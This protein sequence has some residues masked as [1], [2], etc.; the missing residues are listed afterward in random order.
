LKT[1]AEQFLLL[2]CSEFVNQKNTLPSWWKCIWFWIEYSG[3]NVVF[4]KRSSV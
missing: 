2:L 4:S 3:R 1:V